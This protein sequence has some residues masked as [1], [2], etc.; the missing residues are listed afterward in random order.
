V[1]LGGRGGQPDNVGITVSHKLFAPRIGLAYRLGEKTVIRA[2]YGIN[3]DPIPFSRPLRGWYPLTVNQANIAS[4]Y[5]WSTTFEQGVPNTQGPDL[6][7]GI[8]PLPG[9]VSERSPWGGEIH[10]GYTQSWNFTIERKL[11]AD[12]VTSV[13]YVGSGSTHLLADRDINYGYPGSGTT[14]LPYYA[15]YGRTVPT[16]MWDGYLSSHYHSLQVAVNRSFARGLMLK[17]AYTYSHTIDYTDDDGWVSVGWNWPQVFQRNRATAGFDRQ[18]VFTM[19]WVYELPF[20]RGKHLA[21]SG[22]TAA[23]FG[24]WQMNGV[25]SAYSGTPFTV[26]SPGSSLNAPNNTQTANQVNLTVNKIGNF[27]PGTYYYDPTAFAAVTA[28]NTFGTSG[29]NILRAPG[30][31]NTDLNLSREFPFK[32]RFRIQFRA[33]AFNLT[34]TAHFAGPSTS[35]TSSTFMQ[36]TSTISSSS[37]FAPIERQIRFGLRMQW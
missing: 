5:G 26:T 30:L 6:S 1:Y 29:R 22:V 23:I 11:P 8:V 20:G 10:R 7:S 35:V 32:E 16:N 24:N 21:A 13:A 9:N 14:G 27:G 28:P 4:G 19:G 3:F 15:L 25:F 36:I 37:A 12:I 17:G 31:W 33:E 18:Q 34:N 2:G